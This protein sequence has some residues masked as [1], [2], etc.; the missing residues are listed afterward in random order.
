VFEPFAG[1]LLSAFTLSPFGW[2]RYPFLPEHW[3]FRR[4]ILEEDTSPR[5]EVKDQLNAMYP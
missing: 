5:M 2:A 1:F 3:L 4:P